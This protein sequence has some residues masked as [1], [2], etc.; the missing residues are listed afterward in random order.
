[1]KSKLKNKKKLIILIVVV[2][3]ILLLLFFGV[4]TLFFHGSDNAY[5][6]RCSDRDNYKISKETIKKVEK[7]I[8][9]IS[10]VNDIEIYT[11]LCTV[12]I[13]INLDKDV[14]LDVIKN[15]A[16]EVLSLFSED[17]L[18]YYDFALFVTSD[19]KESEIYP[20]NV[21]KHN[22]RDDFAW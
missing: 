8:Q 18:S 9:E 20:I 12:K 2:L 3:L 11:K 17:E 19:N 1:M 10:E 13:I 16:K 14:E 6:D 22:S 5:G 4:K 7:K 15:N 21:S